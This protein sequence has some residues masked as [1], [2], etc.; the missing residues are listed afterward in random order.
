MI[1]DAISPCELWH[2]GVGHIHLKSLPGLEKMVKGI[3][4]FQYEDDG[5]YRGCSL[6]KNIKKSFPSSTKRSKGILE[7]IHLDLR[8]IC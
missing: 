2:R 1:H 7:L 5:I 4:A 3:H 8:V 6:G